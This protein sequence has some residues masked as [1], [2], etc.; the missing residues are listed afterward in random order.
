MR[1]WA[2]AVA[3][4]GFVAYV[5]HYF[6][7]TGD[8]RTNDARENRKFAAWRDA[9]S[10]AVSVI[11][12]DP[13]VDGARVSALGVSLGGYMALALGATDRRVQRLVVV[14]GGLF[15]R[16][17]PAV[18]HLPPTL[19]LHGADDHTVPLA[20]ARR[21]YDL[22]ARLDV[23]R[24]LVVYPHAGHHLDPAERPEVLQRAMAFLEGTDS[25]AVAR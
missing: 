16:L 12:R 25:S 23:P 3:A 24:G 14:S 22:L 18:H 7:R 2:D 11:E 19:L 4:R 21:V 8:T 5:V 13:Q 17:E 6:D 20:E 15:D 9:L 10:D 1:R